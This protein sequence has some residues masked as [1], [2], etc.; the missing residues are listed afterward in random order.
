MDVRRVVAGAAGLAL[1]LA[2]SVVAAG[3]LHGRVIDGRTGLPISG[4]EVT[5]VGLTASV[6]TDAD[7]RFTWE[8]DP[9]PPF[10]VVIILPG[11]AVAQPITLDSL[12]PAAV[13]TLT[14]EAF[15]DSVTV[16]GVAPSIDAAPAAG[17]TLVT[18]QEIKQRAPANLTEALENVPGVSQ[19]SEGQAAVPAVRGL[20]RGRTLILIDGARVTSERRAGPS[21]T[22][23]DPGSVE[24]IDVA[25][26]PG[27]V[28]YG[29]DAFGGV[30][31]VRTRRPD[32]QAPLSFRASGTVG[33]GVPDRRADFEVS[34]G[35]GTGGVLAQFRFAD[36]NDYDGPSDPVINS[37]YQNSGLLFRV[38][39]QVG[40]GLFSA[41]WQSDLGRDVERPRNN[42]DAVRFYYP[43]ENSHRFTAS[44]RHT[45]VD[46]FGTVRVTGLLGRY[47]IRT[48]QDRV[49]TPTD[50]RSI[51]RA[52]VTANDFQVR[53]TSER[54]VGDVK[55][56]MGVDVNG[57][58]DLE[59][60]DVRIAFDEAGAVTSIDDTV[61]IDSARRTD[62]G[63]FV[64][65][66]RSL[67]PHVSAAGGL[68]LDVVNTVNTGG[69]F[70]DK[71][72][73]NGALAG[74]G[75]LTFG[76]FDGV[77]LTAQ[78]A[79]GFREPTISDRFFRGPTGRGFVTGNPDLEPETSLQFDV[80]ARYAAGRVRLAA[81][82]YHYR[83]NDLIERFEA[84]EDFFF[85]RNRGRTRIRG[86][87]TEMQASLGRGY[88][89][90][91]AAQVARGQA[92]DD[93]A[94]LDDIAAP[95]FSVV[96]RKTFRALITSH[97]RVGLTAEDT[98][99]GPSEIVTPGFTS[100]DAGVNWQITPELSLRGSARNLLNQE[101][102]ASP[103]RRWVFAPGR[104]A[105]LA[106]TVQF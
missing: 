87:E 14:A 20:A 106:A 19:V 17:L 80:G 13:L 47:E 38:E 92:L 96:L 77:S 90:E 75:A 4:A 53:V 28:A 18:G 44:Y 102:Y 84:D 88:S 27:S 101:V 49:P 41:G 99:P 97:V 35:F 16:S 36:V 66:E 70:G 86:V 89:L 63:V 91:L 81:Y 95:S 61:S 33:A 8:P 46:G 30:I 64:Q 51:E 104:S 6:T 25:R 9:Q 59:A 93:S 69:Y 82:Y 98:R 54:A 74:F 67:V 15:S 11:G 85:F 78:V 71:S 23:L 21:A 31:S 94:A 5:I 42:S 12:D 1:M 43:F 72:V 83:I 105:S 62:S 58:F 57:R 76:P 39:Q 55:L 7:G 40:G 60:H 24:G 2:G 26:G 3:Q 10:V 56:E 100:L 29:S 34:K 45:D 79:R 50:P 37:G 65:A 73:T 22:Y 68:R 48:D 103:S 32:H 52:D